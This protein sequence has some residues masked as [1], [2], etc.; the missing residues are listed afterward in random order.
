MIQL[1]GQR[2]P[3]RL[4]SARQQSEQRTNL[5]TCVFSTLSVSKQTF[6]GLYCDTKQQKQCLLIKITRAVVYKLMYS[7]LCVL[8]SQYSNKVDF[9]STGEAQIGIKGG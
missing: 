5:Y 4:P 8:I 7:L 3:P 2:G 9:V 1:R 6:S